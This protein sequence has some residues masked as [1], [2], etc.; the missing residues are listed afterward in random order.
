[1]C[2]AR[3]RESG[4]FLLHIIDSVLLWLFCLCLH[5]VFGYSQDQTLKQ[6]K[7]KRQMQQNANIPEV[8]GWTEQA[9]IPWVDACGSRSSFFWQDLREKIFKY[10]WMKAVCIGAWKIGYRLTQTWWQAF[11]AVLYSAEIQKTRWEVYT[12]ITKRN[13][14]RILFP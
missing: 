13:G 9:L 11:G 7:N 14:Y 6:T 4:A 3:H 2:R 10:F 12:E 8:S 1:M 5:Q